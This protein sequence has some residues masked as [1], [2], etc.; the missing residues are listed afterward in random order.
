MKKNTKKKKVK[1]KA[2]AKINIKVKK[3]II[4][5]FQKVMVK[6]NKNMLMIK[7]KF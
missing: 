6:I 3:Y 5:I 2:K 1:V 7:K 4:H